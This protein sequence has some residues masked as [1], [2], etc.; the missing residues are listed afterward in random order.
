VEGKRSRMTR[1][2]WGGSLLGVCLLVAACNSGH[3]S[4]S[5]G[6]TTSS[7]P[8]PT[9][10][11]STGTGV[12]SSL[13]GGNFPISG[14]G[15]TNTTITIG[16][17]TTTGGADPGLF[18]AANDAM[19]AFVLFINSNGGID[20]RR[21]VLIQK[22][23]SGDCATYTSEIASLK[24]QVFALVGGTS[25]ANG[26]GVNTLKAN[27]GLADIEGNIY[28]P[29][30]FP[31]PNVFAGETLPFGYFTTGYEYVKSRFPNSI[32]YYANLY[33]TQGTFDLKEQSA[34]AETIGYKLIYS[35]QV[36]V[37]QSDFTSEILRM[38]SA[39]VK[40]VDL[41]SDPPNTVEAFAQQAAQQGYHPDAIISP[42]AYSAGFFKAL[43]ANPSVANNVIMPLFF[44]LY[45]G[46]DLASHPAL[47]IYLTWLHKA[48]PGAQP[49]YA[50]PVAW[51]AA[52]LFAQALQA[53]GKSGA[54][55]QASLI[56]AL[57]NVGEF[58]ADGLYPA[59]DPNPAHRVGP[60]C[61]TILG[62]KDGQFVFLDPTT[63]GGYE[64]NGTYVNV[65]S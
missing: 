60:H 15:V 34:A 47:G 37:T 21:L 43:G 35:A 22:D 8:T 28:F 50:G 4:S 40:I 17:I 14:P 20:G 12:Y 57:S 2:R 10:A 59:T 29:Q 31:L 55:N 44:P 65:S 32:A 1:L 27:P 53:A 45:L 25:L 38:K 16:Q 42:A 49:A 30:L 41:S 56:T 7:A 64:C 61:A 52:V 33:P 51:S 63:G 54:V 5:S 39:G 19:K 13:F 18:Q 3:S 62:V 11:S 24:S 58:T 6:S 48:V 26:C 36:T 23:D 9:T 46:Q